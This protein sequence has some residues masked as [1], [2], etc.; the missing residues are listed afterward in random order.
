VR[1]GTQ[2]RTADCLV[3]LQPTDKGVLV[4]IGG[5]L[6]PVAA[7]YL[8]ERLAEALRNDPGFV[9]IDLSGASFLDSM[10][11]GLLVSTK[12][13]VSG[14]GGSF[15][16]DGGHSPVRLVLEIM[17]LMEYLNVDSAG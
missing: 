17:G 11:V 16:V 6:D 5:E 3:D 7:P 1:T 15:S 12:R 2:G 9:R 14:Y 8:R 10:A 13:R 4:A